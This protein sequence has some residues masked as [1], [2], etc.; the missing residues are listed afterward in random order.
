MAVT[1][2]DKAVPS[3]E[4]A[5]SM[6]SEAV[7]RMGDSETCP[8]RSTATEGDS[9][10]AA[11]RAARLRVGVMLDG[12]TDRAWV[13]RIIDDI[14]QSDVAQVVAVIINRA[15][16][17]PRWRGLHKRLGHLLFSAYRR[18]DRWFFRRL[19]KIRSDAFD[20]VD[21]RP[22]VRAA[23]VL[24][25]VPLRRRNTD[26]FDAA[27]LEWIGNQ[28]LDVMLR[29]GFGIIR[30][31]ILESAR[32]GVWSFHH[33]DNR[34]YRGTPAM[35]WEMYESNQVCGV[36]L[37]ILTDEL[38]GGKVIYRTSEKTNFYSLYLNQNRNYWK[39]TASVMLRL[40][41]LHA[42]GWPALCELDTYREQARYTK[43]IYRDPRTFVM[44]K[45]LFRLF[46]RFVGRAWLELVTEEQWSIAWRRRPRRPVFEAFDEGQPF[47]LLRPPRGY[48]YADPFLVR[49]RDRHFIFFEDFEY[50]SKRGVISWIELDQKGRPSE[51][52]VALVGDCHLSYPCVFEHDAQMYMIPET[53]SRRRIELWRAERFPDGWTLDRVLIDGINC[54]DTTWLHYHDR[55]WLFS[56]VAMEG[57]MSS[58]ELHVYWSDEPFGPWRPHRQN[59]V[60]TSIQGA[61]PAGALFE[62]DGQLIRTGQDGAKV[63]GHQVNFYRV[64]RLDESEYRE[65]PIGTIRPDW[66]PRNLG[67]HTYNLDNEYEVIDGRVRILRGLRLRR[68]RLT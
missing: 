43:P 68:R 36:T 57:A 21:L 38:D 29:F 20:P 67:T 50:A 28:Q 17:P 53:R 18:C 33:G 41:H 47:R 8:A 40:R 13:A 59:P 42:A 9:G 58:D 32:H 48:F 24:E 65:T 1:K 3:D 15:E 14:E 10:R 31:P 55:Y 2:S 23:D 49:H 60:V 39:A 45:F 30:G 7:A 63:Y 5:H 22:L 37:Q 66:L 11:G 27:S 34:E 12:W 62:S 26:R 54:V 46:A 35:F 56:G 52:R 64:E 4:I 51:P 19:F 25:V 61:R 6:A 16:S 44:L